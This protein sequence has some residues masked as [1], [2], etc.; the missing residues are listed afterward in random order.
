MDRLS[1]RLV[2]LV[3]AA[4]ACL[5]LPLIALADPPTLST[6]VD[7]TAYVPVIIAALLLIVVAGLSAFFAIW[8]FKL[9]IRF[10]SKLAAGRAA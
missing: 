3:M 1:K 6:F 2:A 10:V 9:G 7:L 5:G 4:A 8:V